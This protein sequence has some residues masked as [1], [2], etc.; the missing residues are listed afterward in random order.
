MLEGN[1]AKYQ[2]NS[3][4]EPTKCCSQD[5]GPITLC[6]DNCLVVLYM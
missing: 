5:H 4:A 6:H 2:Y 1:L 3:A